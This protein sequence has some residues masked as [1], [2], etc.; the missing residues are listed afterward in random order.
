MHLIGRRD[1]VRALGL[2]AGAA[3]F[4]PML[5]GMIRE[6]QGQPLTRR[7]LIVFTHANGFIEKMYGRQAASES[8]FPLGGVY[9]PLEPFKQ[10]LLILSKFY[11]PHDRALHGNQFA[12]LS[13][14][15]SPNQAGEKRGPPGGI[16]IDRLLA[17]EIGKEDAF[18]STAV[19]IA[20][21]SKILCV[22]ADGLNQPFPAIGSPVKAFNTYLAGAVEGS[23]Y[24]PMLALAQDRSVL[25]SVRTDIA[26]LEQRLA[27]PERAK[28]E[29]YLTS[30]RATEDRLTRIAQGPTCTDP[31]A[32]GSEL[33]QAKLSPEVVRAHVDVTFQAQLCGMTRIS[34]ISIL[35]M[36]GPHNRYGWLGD[37]KG[38]HNLHHDGDLDIVEKIDTFVLGE[39]AHMFQRLTE[40]PEGNGTMADNSL[41]VYI[42]TC[43]GKH[44]GGQDK[45]AVVMLGSAGGALRTGRYLSY[46]EKQHCISDVFVS[47]AN[48][49]GL[50]ISTFG[51]PEHCKG[52]LPGLA[53]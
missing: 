12:T 14:V 27:A 51:D 29:Q 3:L 43:G 7:R 2:G 39:V 23:G 44:H 37:T 31:V 41:V 35:G 13:V 19:G 45:H 49:M 38:H 8:D 5:R 30:L 50:E 15:P 1:F 17:K 48:A 4:T 22:S 16:S 24:D 28:L 46:P 32:P 10:Q 26:R 21:G 40:I 36:E 9:T 52:P 47:I 25:D 20:E 11:N 53:A 33:D 34:H 18:S 42:N 6:A